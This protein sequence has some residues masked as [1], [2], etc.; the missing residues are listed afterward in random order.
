MGP[1][2]QSGD[3]GGRLRFPARQPGQDATVERAEADPGRR[4]RLLKHPE[5]VRRH[6]PDTGVGAE[7][8]P[9][10]LH[11]LRLAGLLLALKRAGHDTPAGVSS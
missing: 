6:P 11:G 10:A 3:H 4:A 9:D 8:P 5:S 1:G 2:D 7:R